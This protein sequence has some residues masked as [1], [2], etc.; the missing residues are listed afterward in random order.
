MSQ[1]QFKF[2]QF[3]EMHVKFSGL[4]GGNPTCMW[5]L[6][7]AVSIP[8]TSIRHS[9]GDIGKIINWDNKRSDTDCFFHAE[10]VLFFLR[11]EFIFT[12]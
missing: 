7:T 8:S 3:S 11:H 9:M 10:L 4:S 2:F 5:E 6:Q 12:S 1:V